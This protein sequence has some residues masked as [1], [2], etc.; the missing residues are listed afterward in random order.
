M[1]DLEELIREAEHLGDTVAGVTAAE[2]AVRA[3]DVSGSDD[4][5][6]RAREALIQNA[7]FTGLPDKALVAFTWCLALC[8]REPDE[9]PDERMLWSYKWIVNSLDS[10]PQG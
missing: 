7:T 5:R 6:L 4:Q 2:D 8:D 10:F 9:F 1:D 3:A